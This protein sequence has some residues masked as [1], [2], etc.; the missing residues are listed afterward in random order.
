MLSGTVLWCFKCGTYADKKT[1]GLKDERKG[2]PPRQ[3]HRSGMGGQLRKL[4]NGTHPKTGASLPQAVE[5]DPV[6]MPV[7]VNGN[8]V[9]HRPPDGF[10]VYVP[11]DLPSATTAAAAEGM[12]STDRRKA[13]HDRI[14]ANEQAS[15]HTRRNVILTLCLS[16]QPAPSQ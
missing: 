10:Y 6:I 11:A 12:S 1:N 9:A 7:K 4:R 16:G 14:R 15:D 5:L 2:K 3:A 13:L 8:E